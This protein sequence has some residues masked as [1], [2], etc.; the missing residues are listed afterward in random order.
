MLSLDPLRG[1]AALAVVI[2][3]T[4]QAWRVAASGVGTSVSATIFG[5]LGSWGVTL[6]FVLSGFCIHLPQA[7][8]FS[9]NKHHRVDWGGP[10]GHTPALALDEM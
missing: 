1:A 6:F 5:W 9:L 3:H 10:A 7:R 2:H 4:A 8:A